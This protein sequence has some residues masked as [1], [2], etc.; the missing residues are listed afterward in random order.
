MSWGNVNDKTKIGF[1][2]FS[3][4]NFTLFNKIKEKSCHKRI[5]KIGIGDTLHTAK[6]AQN[7][8]VNSHTYKSISWGI[9]F[10]FAVKI[11]EL[12]SYFLIFF[13]LCVF[14]TNSTN[15]K[16]NKHKKILKNDS[17]SFLYCENVI[18]WTLLYPRASY[19]NNN[20]S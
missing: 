5:H 20:V 12:S 13:S 3:Y 17:T 8:I 4:H 7:E 18:L 2:F 15:E 19:Y 11:R 14:C 16:K 6:I 10:K 1:Y 9:F